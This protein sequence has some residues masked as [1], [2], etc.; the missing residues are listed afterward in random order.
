MDWIAF[1]DKLI[2]LVTELDNIALFCTTAIGGGLY[3][4]NKTEKDQ[5]TK[6]ID[7]SQIRNEDFKALAEKEGLKFGAKIIGKLLKK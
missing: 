5:L 7:K 2:I 1:L 6:T 3:L 4:K